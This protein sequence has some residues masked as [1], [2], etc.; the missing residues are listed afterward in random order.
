MHNGEVDQGKR[1]SKWVHSL[2]ILN[3]VVEKSKQ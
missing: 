2:S 1:E 3:K